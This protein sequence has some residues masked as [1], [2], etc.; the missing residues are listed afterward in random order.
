LH[1]KADEVIGR[2]KAEMQNDPSA[3][4]RYNDFLQIL[5]NAR[6]EETGEPL[7]LK[8]LRDEV[9]TFLVRF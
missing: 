4:E 5:L 3:S 6:D 8:E 7:S 9:N 2:R 1:E